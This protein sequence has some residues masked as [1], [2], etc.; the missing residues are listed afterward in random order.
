M[1]HLPYLPSDVDVGTKLMCPEEMVS[2]IDDSLPLQ[3][4]LQAGVVYYE[5][6]HGKTV[7]SQYEGMRCPTVAEYCME[8]IRCRLMNQRL[9]SKDLMDDTPFPFKQQIIEVLKICKV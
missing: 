1:I 2:K 5:D 4:T 9:K 8:L 7:G 3:F 6:R